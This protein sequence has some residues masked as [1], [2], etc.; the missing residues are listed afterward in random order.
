MRI[1]IMSISPETVY[2][3]LNLLDK[4]DVTTSALYRQQAQEILANQKISLQWRQ[5]IADR[6]YQA[7]NRLTMVNIADNDSY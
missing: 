5:K 1:K 7:N 6:L 4:V 2:E 3:N